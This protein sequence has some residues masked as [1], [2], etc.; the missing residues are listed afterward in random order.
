MGLYVGAHVFKI[1]SRTATNMTL[2]CI[3]KD[4]NA[5]YIKIKAK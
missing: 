3:G 4:G 2:R 5:W 1:L